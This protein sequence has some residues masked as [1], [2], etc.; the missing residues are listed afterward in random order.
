MAHKLTEVLC[1]GGHTVS[2]SDS[3]CLLVGVDA[4]EATSTTSMFKKSTL[5]TDERFRFVPVNCHVQLLRAQAYSV[6]E[7][8]TESLRTLSAEESPTSHRR[9]SVSMSAIG[10]S[11]A[12]S[13]AGDPT[14]P[15][16]FVKRLVESHL[17]QSAVC[18]LVTVSMGA[19]VAHKE[20][21][22]SDGILQACQAY[23]AVSII[24]K[25]LLFPLYSLAPLCRP[26]EPQHQATRLIFCS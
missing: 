2:F 25:V 7:S 22:C 6:V 16:R 3:N 17:R 5:K 19:P 26:C 10:H 4:S 15:L 23:A 12:T 9:R 18:N 13:T 1:S 14:K 21:C 24:V 11:S 20:P 8:S